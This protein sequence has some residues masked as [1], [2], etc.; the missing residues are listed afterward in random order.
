[1]SGERAVLDLQETLAS[2]KTVNIHRLLTTDNWPLATVF[3]DHWLLITVFS[4]H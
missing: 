4:D 3:S 2:Q 1:M